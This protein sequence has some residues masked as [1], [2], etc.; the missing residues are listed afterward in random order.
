MVEAAGFEPA[1]GNHQP[2]VLH[3]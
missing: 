3:A 2:V 1:S